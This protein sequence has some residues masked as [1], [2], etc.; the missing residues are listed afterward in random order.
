M[1]G[2]SMDNIEGIPLYI[3]PSHDRGPPSYKF[4]WRVQLYRLPFKN[5]THFVQL[6]PTGHNIIIYP[7]INTT[8]PFWGTLRFWRQLYRNPP[9]FPSQPQ[10]NLIQPWLWHK[11]EC[12]NPPPPTSTTK[13]QYWQFLSCYW[14]DCPQISKVKG[15]LVYQSLLNKSFGKR[16]AYHFWWLM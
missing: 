16:K 4:F 9:S 8:F 5:S 7:F 1:L 3:P 12:A 6:S 11:N 15:I 13:T 14:P 10:L 2:W